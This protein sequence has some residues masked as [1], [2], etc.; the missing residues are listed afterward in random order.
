[1][2]QDPQIQKLLEDLAK[3]KFSF[4]LVEGLTNY[5]HTLEENFT[6]RREAVLQHSS[7]TEFELLRTKALHQRALRNLENLERANQELAN[8]G[9]ALC[10]S[11]RAMKLHI[12]A[13]T[14]PSAGMIDNAKKHAA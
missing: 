8:K 4:R 12:D 5:I 6:I 3:G 7:D 2:T 11:L 1:M 9:L 13:S 10:E 14:P